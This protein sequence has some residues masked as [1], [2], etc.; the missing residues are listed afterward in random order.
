MN[1]TI[2][3]IEAIECAFERFRNAPLSAGGGKEDLPFHKAN[4]RLSTMFTEEFN[5][6]SLHVRRSRLEFQR[7]LRRQLLERYQIDILN[8][9]SMLH[10]GTEEGIWGMVPPY[11]EIVQENVCIVPRLGDRSPPPRTSINTAILVDGVH[12]AWIAREEGI[13]LQCILVSGVPKKYPLP[14]AYPNEWS[15]IKIY[16]NPPKV[17]KF[18][19][20]QDP[21]TLMR[22]IEVMRQ[23]DANPPQPE[24]GR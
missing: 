18:Y 11:V 3:R 22:P 7:E 13:P 6:G 10:I 1:A 23:T 15:Q 2:V 14:Y 9:S 8:L 12:R 5:P 4:I 16:D 20:R 24:W 19:R 21:Y 17:K